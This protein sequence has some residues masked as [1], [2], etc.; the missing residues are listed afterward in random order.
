MSGFLVIPAIDLLSGRCVRLLKGDYNQAT[1]YSDDPLQVARAFAEAGASRLHVV[2]LDAA[3]GTG[4]NRAAVER[5][6]AS[7]ELEVE[8]AGGVRTAADAASWLEAGA[9]FVAMATTAV[10]EP[11]VFAGC[12]HAHPGSI[13]AALDLRNGRPAVGG[14]A[15]MAAERLDQ[16]VERWAALPLAAVEVTSVERDGTL[17]G[18]DL[19]ALA[20]VLGLTE[21]PVIYGG[22]IGS[23]PDVE[24]VA[25]TGAAGAI[26]GKALYEGRLDLKAALAVD[27]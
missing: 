24:A 9:R 21:Q 1:E 23:L 4:D 2:D 10:R 12:A 3:R 13:L 20:E 22:G 19:E 26:L 14:W 27:R 5:I 18:P 16:L 17:A 15:D 7:V 25:H 11:E 8:V 6:A